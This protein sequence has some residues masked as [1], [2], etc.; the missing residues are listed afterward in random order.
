MIG[1]EDEEHVILP[2]NPGEFVENLVDV[3]LGRGIHDIVIAV[4]V[5]V[6]VRI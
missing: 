2:Q 1:G 6:R 5:Q 4:A 3:L